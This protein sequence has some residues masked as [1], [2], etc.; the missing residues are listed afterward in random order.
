MTA[1]ALDP[2]VSGPPRW[3]VRAAHAAALVTL[4]TGIWRLL[5]ATGHTAGY[6]DAGYGAMGFTGWGAVYVVGLSVAGEALAL[7]TLGLV[8]PWGEVLPRWIPLLGGR[9]VRPMAAVVPAGLAALALTVLWTPFLAWWAL[10]HPH[11]TVLGQTLVGFLYLPLVAWGP[12]LGAVTVSYHRRR[13]AVRPEL[14]GVA[15]S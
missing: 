3:A 10:P 13:R 1:V 2:A 8:R 6:T 5:L 12:L 4:P 15:P 14:A 11:M 9:R 7:L